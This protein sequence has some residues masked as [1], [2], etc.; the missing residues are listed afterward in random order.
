[1][2][3]FCFALL[4]NLL[5][6]VSDAQCVISGSIQTKQP[7]PVQLILLTADGHYRVPSVTISSSGT[8][9]FKQTVQVSHPTFALLKTDNW[10][11]RLL[12][13]PGR[14]LQADLIVDSIAHI[15]FNSTGADENRL[16]QNGVFSEPPFFAHGSSSDNP[17]AKIT[18]GEWNEKII[19]P[20]NKEISEVEKSVNKSSIPGNLKALL[21]SETKYAYQ[22][23]LNDFTNN[24]L[25]WVKNPDEDTLLK[26]AMTWQQKPDSITLISG[27]YANMSMS[28]QSQYEVN[29]MARKAK[30]NKATLPEEFEKFLHVPFKVADSLVKKYGERYIVD[31]LYARI[32]SLSQIRD[33][34]LYNK[35]MDA[36]NDASFA[37]GYYLLDT[38]QYHYP[39]SPYLKGA[40][41]EMAKV[42]Q[43]LTQNG[44]N[45]KIRYIKPGTVSTLNDLVK[46]YA[47]KIVYL[48][49]WGTWC[50]P[51]RVEMGYVKQLKQKFAGKDVVFVYLDMDDDLK[52]KSWKEYISYFNI[53]GEHYRMTQEEIQPIWKEIKQAGGSASGYPTYVLFD[54]AGKIISPDAE[55]P[56]TRE[57]LYTQLEKAL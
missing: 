22:C 19:T 8:G 41:E 32:Y 27:F 13:S 18:L 39:N 31:W 10:E 29:S 34:I 57:K 37:A 47:G 15:R 23:Y 55:R 9:P 54:R 5:F 52:E 12:L 16:I 26:L 38:L 3:K 7:V 48:D 42:T 44:D 45:E 36:A 46:P 2:K 56:S 14:N 49:V 50:G 40:R 51:C 30:Q 6:K 17:Y 1:M 53:E 4:I 43:Q 25:R 21:I 28:R 20:I 33:K 24:T 11:K 35:I